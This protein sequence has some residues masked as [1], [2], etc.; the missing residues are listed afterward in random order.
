MNFIVADREVC[1]TVEFEI[2]KLYLPGIVQIPFDVKCLRHIAL[3]R[4]YAV[5]RDL[6]GLKKE[7]GRSIQMPARQRNYR[8]ATPHARGEK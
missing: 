1:R 3:N 8:R 2:T 4:I 5:I 6:D 7:S